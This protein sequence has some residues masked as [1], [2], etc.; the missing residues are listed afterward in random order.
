MKPSLKYWLLEILPKTSIINKC[1]NVLM[2]IITSSLTSS[3]SSCICCWVESKRSFSDSRFCSSFCS[4]YKDY[5][6]TVHWLPDWVEVYA[7]S[8]SKAIFKARTCSHNLF[9]LVI[10][11]WWMKLGGN[12]PLGHDALLFWQVAQDLLYATRTT[13]AFDYPAMDCWGKV[14]V[15][16]YQLCENLS[17]HSRPCSPPDHSA[18]P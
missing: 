5:I 2:S 6:G 3:S 15:V 9:S 13:K 18:P 12:L 10:I 8:A 4:L 16:S 17:V 1:S 11:T 7:L 14:K